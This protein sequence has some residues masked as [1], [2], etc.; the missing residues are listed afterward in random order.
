MSERTRI[1]RRLPLILADL[2]AGSNP[3]YTDQLLARTAAARQRPGWAFLERWLPMGTAYPATVA[4]P[5]IPWRVVGTLALLILVIVVGALVIA[6]NQ[7]RPLPAPP[8]GLAANGLLAYAA[9]GDILTS[10]PVSGETSAI[11]TGPDEDRDPVW[12]RDGTR[13]VFV[14]RVEDEP[15]DRLYVVRSDG[16]GL[17]ELTTEPVRGIG[18][19]SFSPDGREVVFVSDSN[20]QGTMHIAEADGSGVETLDVGMAALDPAFRPP[21][22]KEIAFTGSPSGETTITGIYLVNMDGSELRM[23]VEPARDAAAGSPTWSPDGSLI[24]YGLVDFNVAEWTSH[25]RIMSADG[26]DDRA[27]PMPADARFNYNAT[28]SNDGT[29]LVMVRGYAIS[30]EGDNVAAVVPADGSGSGLE[31]ARSQ[32][33]DEALGFEWAPNDTSIVVLRYG[34]QGL[35]LGSRLMDPLTGAIRP[36][37]TSITG[38]PS[39]QR[40]APSQ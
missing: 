39:W 15:A 2:G 8:F 7:P 19:Y 11:V 17:T 23:L 9:D 24:A 6:G 35:P 26:S 22:G 5:R 36:A 21:D 14:R 30:G 40:L 1:E 18:D 38:R 3:D 34:S 25:T 13:L 27:L 12:S 16:T 37:P 32:F 29:R 20:A 10:D 4:T 31:T 33:P 28:W